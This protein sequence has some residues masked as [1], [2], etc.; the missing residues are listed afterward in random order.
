MFRLEGVH[1]YPKLIQI[2]K[3]NTNNE[4]KIQSK[5]TKFLQNNSEAG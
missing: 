4:D 5:F 3:L 2:K 1:V